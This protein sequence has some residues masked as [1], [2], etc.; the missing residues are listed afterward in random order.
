VLFYSLILIYFSIC[1][2]W[3]LLTCSIFRFYECR[4]WISG[5]NMYVCK[6][7]LVQLEWTPGAVQF[8]VSSGLRICTSRNLCMGVQR[9][10]NLPCMGLRS[11]H[12]FQCLPYLGLRSFAPVFFYLWFSVFAWKARDVRAKCL[13]L[14]SRRGKILTS[15]VTIISKFRRNLSKVSKMWPAC[16]KITWEL[17]I[18]LSSLHSAGWIWSCIRKGSRILEDSHCRVFFVMLET[19][20]LILCYRI[21]QIFRHLEHCFSIVLL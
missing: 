11:F 19:W 3:C 9:C 5:M 8:Y 21:N 20:S 7:N 18:F 2:V 13:H 15:A 1:L 17:H 12:H 14:H 4:D 6:G 10:G 16:E